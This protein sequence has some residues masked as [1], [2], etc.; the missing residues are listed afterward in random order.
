[1]P[2]HI[3]LCDPAIIL[4][5][6]ARK[7]KLRPLVTERY[8]ETEPLRSLLKKLDVIPASDFIQGSNGEK[9]RRFQKAL[10]EIK[11]GLERGE[12]ILFYPAGR[13]MTAPLEKMQGTSGLY[14]LL[15]I[16]PDL[17]VI[18]VRT[19][20]LWGSSFSTAPYGRTPDMFRQVLWGIKVVLANLIFFMPKRDVTISFEKNPIPLDAKW[21]REELNAKVEAY[22][23]QD[24]EEPFVSPPYHFLFRGQWFRRVLSYPPVPKLASSKEDEVIAEIQKLTSYKVTRESHLSYDLAL[25]SLEIS[26]LFIFLQKKYHLRNLYTYDLITPAHIALMIEKEWEPSRIPYDVA[27]K[28][29]RFARYLKKRRGCFDE[30][31][32]YIHK[33]TIEKRV[34][35]W[36]R[37]FTEEPEEVIQL[38]VAGGIDA[39][40]A[41]MAVEE[42]CKQ[43]RLVSPSD[44]NV[45]GIVYT[46]YDTVFSTQ[47]QEVP[48]AQ[49]QVCYLDKR[50]SKAPK[51]KPLTCRPKRFDEASALFTPEPAL[52][53][54]QCFTNDPTLSVAVTYIALEK[55]LPIALPAETVANRTWS[56]LMSEGIE[57]VLFLYTQPKKECSL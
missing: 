2:N 41:L 26:K 33:K 6:L 57:N 53:V 31:E 34:S 14:R 52:V 29:R 12:N 28:R 56:Q 38:Y 7:Q 17:D 18:L 30:M 22:Y 5:H 15:Q 16:K 25:D 48:W 19:Q 45:N 37:V 47:Q 20:G 35:L 36:A 39:F 49:G 24:G 21:S 8:C 23:N 44:E 40:C 13:L 54:N 3:A 46:T 32:G 10:Y 4:A 27:K 9:K 50:T 55:N 1:M 43:F 11:E 42:A 51:G